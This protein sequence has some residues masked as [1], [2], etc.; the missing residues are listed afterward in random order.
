MDIDAL[1][2][3]T[4]QGLAFPSGKRAL[5][6]SKKVFLKKLYKEL[7]PWVQD[8]TSLLPLIDF[9]ILCGIPP[10]RSNSRSAMVLT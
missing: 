5:L 9:M 3:L 4:Y 7:N 10:K 6:Y 1:I 2:E 8:Q